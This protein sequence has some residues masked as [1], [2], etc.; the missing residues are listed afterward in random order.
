M[1]FYKHDIY[2][3]ERTKLLEGILCQSICFTNSLKRDYTSFSALTTP[4]PLE[5]AERGAYFSPLEQ[6]TE[7]TI[8]SAKEFFN[9]YVGIDGSFTNRY[10]DY[11]FSSGTVKITTPEGE[12]E[13]T[14]NE[15]GTISVNSVTL[16]SYAIKVVDVNTI[17]P[18][19]AS[20]NFEYSIATYKS[21]LPLIPYSI[22]DCI[23]RCLDLAIPISVGEQRKYKLQGENYNADGSRNFSGQALEL[24]KIRAPQFTMTSCTLRE[25]LKVIGGYIHAEPRLGYKDENGNYEEDTIYFQYY[26]KG[27]NS[28]LDGLSYVHKSETQS[29][30]EYCTDVTT[31]AK[32]LVS[33]IDYAKGVVID[34]MGNNYR[35]LRT[36]TV[37]IKLTE[38]NG[39]IY[40]HLPIYRL[41]KL[42]CVLYNADG[43]EAVGNTDITPF[44]FEEYEYNSVLSS[45]RGAYPYVKAYALYYRQG[46]RNI[47][48][49]F[50]KPEGE[51]FEG[52]NYLKNYAIVN[53]LEAATGQ[54]VKNLVTE[55]FP[56]LSFRVT[57]QPIYDTKY[58]H[59]KQLI[60]SGSKPF[61]TIYNQTEN[62]LEQ[63][64]Y[65]QNVKGVAQRLG[66][67]EKTM[68]FL[69]PRFSMRPRTGQKMGNFYVSAVNTELH[70]N[71]CKSTVGLS[72]DFNRLSAYVGINSHK[73]VAEVSERESYERKILIKDYI[74]VG[75][76]IR[77]EGGLNTYPK[78]RCIQNISFIK[79]VF[80]ISSSP[81]GDP[82]YDVSRISAAR[83]QTF[84]KKG[85]LNPTES[86]LCSVY[87]SLIASASGNAM[88]F[89]W[90]YKDNYSAAEKIQQIDYSGANNSITGAWQ[91]DIPYCDTYGRAYGFRF[92]LYDKLS[93]VGSD[94]ALDPEESE[95]IDPSALYWSGAPYL[96]RKDSREIPIF[97]YEIEYVTNREDLNIGSALSYMCAYINGTGAPAKAKAFFFNKELDPMAIALDTT[98]ASAESDIT[99]EL[100]ANELIGDTVTLSFD[101]PNTTFSAWA[102]CIPTQ[103]SDTT[104]YVDEDGEVTVDTK[105]VAGDILISAKI[106]NTSYANNAQ[107]TIYFQTA[108]KIYN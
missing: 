3:I 60:I 2:S 90:K 41:N 97:N 95:E 100:S 51:T 5:S 81:T 12:T 55:G 49:L 66:Q 14:G 11:R 83:C 88:V 108:S 27:G 28:N 25:Q 22:T 23:L 21:E 85:S 71:Y 45:Y 101:I 35:S 86:P 104:T 44:V 42:E 16:I 84:D 82:T 54:N 98:E 61:T 102:V 103:E 89:T 39:F 94:F 64:H 78:A 93:D 106:P 26:N 1:K 53:I 50:F 91:T 59:S 20:L 10:D 8:K 57:Y 69:L 43:T 73:R 33:S 30:N 62:T 72:R 7:L 68:T 92:A 13:Y 18:A 40:T 31:D 107:E 37:N 79:S 56:Y 74:V 70:H 87:L 38:S 24:S 48:G 77:Y 9:Y 67:L 63:L 46:E 34:P 29:L 6:G 58:S 17:A 19:T 99:F 32:N 76:K 15:S 47:N 75:N 96:L 65:G 52:E 105:I 4:I 36:D 80:G